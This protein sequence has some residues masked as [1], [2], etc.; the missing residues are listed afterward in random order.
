MRETCG[1]GKAAAAS[2]AE[3]DGGEGGGA[4]AEAGLLGRR[5][6]AEGP[7]FAVGDED[8]VV[9][10]AAGAARLGRDLALDPALV[11]RR[12]AVG[13]GEAQDRDE[14]GAAVGVIEA[15]VALG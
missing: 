14:G 3:L 1:G 11:E 15:A 10:E 6:L 8:R 7:A 9:A 4:V 5:H 12:P 13:P 2:A